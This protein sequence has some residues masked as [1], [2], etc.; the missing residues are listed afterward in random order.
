M[1]PRAVP[2]GYQIGGSLGLANMV[3]ASPRR[4]GVGAHGV[5]QSSEMH[6]LA[7]LSDCAS[8]VQLNSATLGQ[9]TVDSIYILYVQLYI[10]MLYNL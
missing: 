4:L 1:A 7:R 8:L 9:A 3:P 10:Y 2:H 5:L 6:S